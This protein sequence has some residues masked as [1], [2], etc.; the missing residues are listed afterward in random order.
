MKEETKRWIERAERDYVSAKKNFKIK[1]YHIVAFLCQQ[2]AEKSLKAMIIEKFSDIIKTHDLIFLAKKLE[3]SE[4]IIIAVS[5]LNPVYMETRYPDSDHLTYDYS[6]NDA[7]YFLK[8]CNE[9]LSWIR[10]NL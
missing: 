1:E 4:E 8:Y 6:K 5:I 2:A 7:E 10:K 3:A 9:V